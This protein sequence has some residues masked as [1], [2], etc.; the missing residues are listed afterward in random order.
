MHA[1]T[2]TLLDF[3]CDEDDHP[4]PFRPLLTSYRRVANE[5]ARA[6]HGPEVTVALRKLLESRDCALR[7]MKL[8]AERETVP[9]SREDLIP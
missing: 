5:V 8:A 7:A 1:G 9:V 2:Q 4:E 3:F 6:D